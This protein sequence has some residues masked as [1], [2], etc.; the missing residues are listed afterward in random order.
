MFA[1]PHHL[2]ALGK[3]GG[4]EAGDG[5][6]CFH[7]F[8]GRTCLA[9][10][11]VW[12]MPV[13]HGTP[14][15]FVADRPPA[16][17]AIPSLA[18]ALNEDVKY[19]L[20]GNVFRG[21]ADTYFPAKVLAKVGRIVEINEELRGLKSGE[22]LEYSDADEAMVE[23]SASSV[24][25]V[26]LPSDDDVAGLLDDLQR[27]VEIWLKPGGKKAKGAEAEFLYD[28]S[29]GGL[30][31]CGC[32]FTFTRGHEGDGGCSNSYPDC[33]AVEDVNEDFGNAFYNDHHFHYGYHIYAAAVVA[34]HRPEWGREYFQRVLL[35]I[36]DIANPSP[37][38]KNFPAFRQ[39][40][41][42]TTGTFLFCSFR[43][44]R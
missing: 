31:N 7:T 8:H 22:R 2:E 6:S 9:R 21:A 42:H 3:A 29:W 32:N 30:V 10:G 13:D 25:E 17:D 36:R 28:T 19:K 12:S 23:E 38:D 35:Y 43:S 26:S 34:K 39:K 14:Q 18:D 24:A 27:A 15:S 16:P 41:S 5:A 33:P 11:S 1:L 44:S 20:S 40:V 4:D 37:E